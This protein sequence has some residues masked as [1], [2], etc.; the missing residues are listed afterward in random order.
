[1][2]IVSHKEFKAFFETF[3]IPVYTLMQRYTGERELSRDFTQEAFVRVFEHWGEFE[4]EENAKAFLY[5]VA[6]RIYLDHCKHQKIENQYQNRVNEEE[7]EEYD[8]LK[9][10]TQQEVS[11]ILYD[12]VDKLPSQTRS[13]ILLNLKGFNN[14]EVAERLGVS[15]NT[16]KSLKKSAYVTLRTL[17]SKDLLMILFVLVDK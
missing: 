2:A 17:L 13:I 3:F 14:T 10:V 7:L 16:I 1:M 11:R 6:R 8:F 5:T 9:E 12:A 15:V 4:T